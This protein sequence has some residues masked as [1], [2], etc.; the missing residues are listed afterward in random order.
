[1]CKLNLL[2][3]LSS[4]P[5]I[6]KC[7]IRPH[8]DYRDLIY[9][10]LNLSSLANKIKSVQYSTTFTI[11]VTIRG[12]S[13]EKLFR[14]L[15]CESLKIRRWLKRLCYLYKTVSTKQHAYLYDLIPL[16]QRSLQNKDCICRSLYRI[17]PF[18]NSFLPYAIKEWNKLHPEIRNAEI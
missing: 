4:L 15:G 17:V 18:K 6:Y 14:E 7:F 1:M 10:Q 3:P 8:M 5:T 2:L 9:D 11:T 13:K 12:I 16:F